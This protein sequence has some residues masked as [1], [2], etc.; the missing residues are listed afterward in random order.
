MAAADSEDV[1]FFNSWCM[2]FKL[3]DSTKAWL[4]ENGCNCNTAIM[5]L[6]KDDIPIRLSETEGRGVEN[7]GE[8]IKIITG[9]A[10]LQ[11]HTSLCFL[12]IVFMD[13]YSMYIFPSFSVSG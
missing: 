7:L 10:S 13:N 3:K 11:T 8:R 9:V 5:H 6:F 2:E 12:Y 1:E 4:I